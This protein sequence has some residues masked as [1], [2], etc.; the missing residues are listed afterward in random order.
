MGIHP[1]ALETG[2]SFRIGIELA[3][4][5]GGPLRHVEPEEKEEGEV[6]SIPTGFAREGEVPRVGKEITTSLLTTQREKEGGVRSRGKE[7]KGGDFIP[8]HMKRKRKRKSKLYV[9]FVD[10]TVFSSPF[11]LHL[12]ASTGEEKG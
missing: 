4:Q 6:G 11:Y 10:S 3:A 1:S 2:G 12:D 9:L 5:R 8:Y 7:K